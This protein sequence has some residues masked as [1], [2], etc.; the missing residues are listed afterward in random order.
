M[1][2]AYDEESEWEYGSDYFEDENEWLREENGRLGEENERL[3]EENNLLTE[4]NLELKA[5]CAELEERIEYLKKKRDE[6]KGKIE[7][8][9]E[10]V[11]SKRT[12]IT[13]MSERMGR[14]EWELMKDVFLLQVFVT[15]FCPLPLCGDHTISFYFSCT[16]LILVKS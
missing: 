1:N 2:R 11:H 12:G 14:E 6:R 9:Q 8:L 16:N 3:G 10:E 4:E 15:F 5:D 13:A 7:Q